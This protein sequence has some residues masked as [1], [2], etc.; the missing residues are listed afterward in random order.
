MKFEPWRELLGQSPRMEALIH[1]AREC[2]TK[3]QDPQL[4][5][6]NHKAWKEAATDLKQVQELIGLSVVGLVL[7]PEVARAVPL[8]PQ[9]VEPEVVKIPE[10]FNKRLTAQLNESSVS[11]VE[12]ER[13]IAQANERAEFV[14][15]L[16]SAGR[17]LFKMLREKDPALM[18]SMV[19][20]TWPENIDQL[21][22]L[23]DRSILLWLQMLAAMHQTFKGATMSPSKMG[24]YYGGVSNIQSARTLHIEGV[25]VHGLSQDHEPKGTSWLNDAKNHF[26]AF[27]E[28]VAPALPKAEAI[29]MDGGT[30]Q[31]MVTEL[32]DSLDEESFAFN[33][34]LQHGLIALQDDGLKADT[35]ICRLLAPFEDMLLGSSL[36]GLRSQVKYQAEA[37][38]AAEDCVDSK[39]LD[40]LWPC[41]HLVEGKKV[42]MIGSLGKV[43]NISAIREGLRIEDD[44]FE[45]VSANKPR[46]V[47]AASASLANKEGCVV[48]VMQ[49]CDS[50]RC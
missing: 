47:Q 7:T 2:W 23:S 36:R 29:V 44:N 10:D 33:V 38:N 12:Q 26:D 43:H 14:E 17:E 15:K 46:K 5:A 41:W 21:G 20:L 16:T 32:I 4:F 34:D 45:Y 40:D 9:P 13:L 25:F 48:L 49:R 42:F 19:A 28:S 3:I 50:Q 31:R 22:L 24:D 1:R 27:V 35:R 8:P 6:H 39:E 11:D 30:A 18:D 37:D